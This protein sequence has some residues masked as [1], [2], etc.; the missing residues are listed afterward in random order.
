MSS[1]SGTLFARTATA[2]ILLAAFLTLIWKPEL[3]LG[4]TLFVVGLASVGLYEYYGIVRSAQIVPEAAGGIVAGALVVFSGHA[5]LPVATAFALYGASL[6]VATLHI[7]RKQYSVAGL[8]ASVFGVVYIGWCGAH[9]ILLHGIPGIGPGLATLLLLAVALSDAGAYFVGRTCGKHKMAP[10]LS[11]NKTWEGASGGLLAA[12]AGMAAFHVVQA[13]LCW[14][15]L[16]QWSFGYCVY[17]GAV[18]SIVAQI[19]DLTESCL[20]RSAGVKDSGILFPGHGGVLDRCDGYLFAAPIL[21]YM[22]A[23]VF[24]G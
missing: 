11:P 5:H 18:L 3:R 23:P 20:K 6:L 22:T 8:A 19:G 10:T 2:L 1:K 15:V 14:T 7:V 13:R 4:F 24:S 21:Y 12:L 17:V 9:L 16:P